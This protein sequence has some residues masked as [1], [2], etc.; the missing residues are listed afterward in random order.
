MSTQ[1]AIRLP[2][3]LVAELDAMVASGAARSRASVIERALAK[4]IRQHRYA[5][6]LAFYEA[7]PEAL[8]DPDMDAL[9]AWGAREPMDLD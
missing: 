8:E 6:E 1:I 7:H 5:Q 2:D 3:H 4:A 9:A